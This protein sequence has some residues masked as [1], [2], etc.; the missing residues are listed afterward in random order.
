MTTKFPKKQQACRPNA[1]ANPT[2]ETHPAIDRN[3][4]AGTENSLGAESVRDG[5]PATKNDVVEAND[6]M[7]PGTP[8]E[9]S[10]D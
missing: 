3:A 5:R 4:P 10:R 9:K 7:D 2:A 1:S 6:E 8:S